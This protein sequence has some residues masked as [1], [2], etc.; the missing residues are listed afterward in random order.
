MGQQYLMRLFFGRPGCGKTTF[1]AKLLRNSRFQ[2]YCNFDTKIAEQISL[3]GLGDRWVLPVASHLV[4]DEASVEFN[5]R[6][7]KAMK[8]G[9][10]QWFKLHRHYRCPVDLFSQA[11]DD[12]DITLRRL[13]DEIWYLRRIGPFTFA[14]KVK[15]EVCIDQ[16]TQQIIDGYKFI[17]LWH[18]LFLEKVLMCCYRPK[19]YKFFNSFEC[20]TGIPVKYSEGDIRDDDERSFDRPPRLKSLLDHH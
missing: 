11:W 4:I 6:D 18:A 19:Y 16:Q 20:P 2:R 15:K 17:P 7:Y 10:R 5:N 13:T 9:T 14:R 8:P 1:A 3:D 12:V